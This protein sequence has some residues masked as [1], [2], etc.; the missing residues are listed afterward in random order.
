MDDT[1]YSMA[2]SK[3]EARNPSDKTDKKNGPSFFP[4]LPPLCRPSSSF[5][6]GKEGLTELISSLPR[7]LISGANKKG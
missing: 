1:H 6:E 4:P 2:G 5:E 7:G 3:G